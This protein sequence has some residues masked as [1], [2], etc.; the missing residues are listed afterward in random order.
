M[1]VFRRPGGELLSAMP[2]KKPKRRQ[3][4][5]SDERFALLFARPLDPHFT[6]ASNQASWFVIAKAR[7]DIDWPPVYHRCR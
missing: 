7:V 2:R 1:G 4:A 3:G 5:G 6:G